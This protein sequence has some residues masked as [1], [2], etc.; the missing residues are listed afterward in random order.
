ME[1]T[2]NIP[3]MQKFMF[4]VLLI[5]F[6]GG[7]SK[8]LETE[9]TITMN[10]FFDESVREAVEKDLNSRINASYLNLETGETIEEA[11]P[12]I[13]YRLSCGSM[14]F[15]AITGTEKV[16]LKRFGVHEPSKKECENIL[17]DQQIGKGSIVA[18]KGWYTCIKTHNGRIGWIRYD[19]D[20]YSG[21]KPHEIQM[22]YWIWEGIQK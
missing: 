13:L 7:C 11:G 19:K 15:P 12:D 10:S 18:Q 2:N 3:F 17:G 9:R 14:C 8:K 6:I 16:K 20:F 1:N 22:T 21:L 4:C 5:L